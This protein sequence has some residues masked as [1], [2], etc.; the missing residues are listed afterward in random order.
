MIKVVGDLYGFFLR[1]L[2]SFLDDAW[3]KPEESNVVLSI[4]KDAGCRIVLHG[5]F[6]DGLSEISS[7]FSCQFA[8]SYCLVRGQG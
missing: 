7:G 8:E 3:I 2:D 6:K 5:V 4:A 1:I